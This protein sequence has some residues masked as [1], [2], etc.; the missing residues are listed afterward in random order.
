M[1]IL[2]CLLEGNSYEK[3]SKALFLARSSVHYR[4]RCLEKAIGVT[5]LDE[6]KDFLRFNQFEDIIRMN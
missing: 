2:K 6:L 4:I 1:Q 3:I 5:T